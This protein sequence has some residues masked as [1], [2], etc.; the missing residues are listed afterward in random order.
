M[1]APRWGDIQPILLILGVLGL[2]ALVLSGFMSNAVRRLHSGDVAQLQVLSV[3]RGAV[4]WAGPVA[5]AQRHAG[6]RAR[7]AC[8]RVGPVPAIELA[9][10][11]LQHVALG[12]S[13]LPIALG[14]S[15]SNHLERFHFQRERLILPV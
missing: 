3:W 6:Q 12:K 2:Q 4:A 1:R 9:E 11:T 13:P 10:R 14:E 7:R 15:Q 8:L 5:G